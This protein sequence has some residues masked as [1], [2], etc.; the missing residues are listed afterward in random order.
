MSELQPRKQD[1]DRL[2]TQYVKPLEKDHKGE[3]VAVSLQGKTILAPTLLEVMQQAEDIFGPRQTVV[4]K[5]GAKSVGRL[6]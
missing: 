6:L 3:Y 4:F 1:A 5:V 2:Y